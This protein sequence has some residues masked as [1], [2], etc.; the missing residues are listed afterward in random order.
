[1][2]KKISKYT[3]NALVIIEAL[4]LGI[5][6]VEG[7]EIPYIVQITGVMSAIEGVISSYL[8]SGK[9]INKMTNK[10]SML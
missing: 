9:A 1:M 4:L 2:L 5:N 6:A 8:L 7:I 3:L 10:Q